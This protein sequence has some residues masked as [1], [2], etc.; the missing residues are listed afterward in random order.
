MMKAFAATIFLAFGVAAAPAHAFD[1]YALRVLGFSPDGRHFGFMYYGPHLDAQK[2]Y[3]E[4]AVIDAATDRFV[5]GSPLKI[6]EEMKDDLVDEKFDAEVKAFVVR[7]EK[8]AAKLAGQYKIAKP[9]AVLARVESARSGEYETGPD[10]PPPEVG[11]ASLV[12]KHPLLGEMKFV[13]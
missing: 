7:A 3:A 6:T 10:L 13:L 11:A 5:A 4:V 2:F 8:R 1:T 12:A 9:G